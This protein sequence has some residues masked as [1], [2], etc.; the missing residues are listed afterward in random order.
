VYTLFPKARYWEAFSS[1]K[2]EELYSTLEYNRFASSL[3]LS[4]YSIPL[5]YDYLII[6]NGEL[7]KLRPDIANP[8][9]SYFEESEWVKYVS[10]RL[11]QTKSFRKV[12][13]D[14][15]RSAFGKFTECVRLLR[16]GVF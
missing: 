2:D 10:R 15:I 16:V 1:A 6:F 3:G 14:N 7:Y 5:S 8:T 9:R 4:K 13:Q 12:F 11:D